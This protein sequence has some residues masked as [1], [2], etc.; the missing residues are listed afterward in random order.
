MCNV[1]NLDLS[2]TW[3][4]ALGFANQPGGTAVG[5]GEASATE[6]LILSASV[7]LASGLRYG[8]RLHNGTLLAGT[9]SSVYLPYLCRHLV[10]ITGKDQSK[11]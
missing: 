11:L 4:Q 9:S 10:I 1:N 5:V 7:L 8:L 2:T 3:V 6:I